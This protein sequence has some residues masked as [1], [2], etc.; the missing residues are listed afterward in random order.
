MDF[1]L[2]GQ[3]AMLQDAMRQ[4]SE[5]DIAPV[6]AA[7]SPDRPL[8]KEAMQAIYAVL[9]HNGLTAPRLPEAV[10][11]GGLSMLEYGLAFEQL[12]PTVA[13]S[14]VAHEGTAAR[15]Y[16][17]G[18]EAAMA[19][20]PSLIAGTLIGCTGSSEPGGGSDPRAVKTRA[21]ED[22]KDLLIT[23]RKMW[24]TNG[25]IADVMIVTCASGQDARGRGLVRRVVV[26]RA[27]SPYEAREIDVIG[28]RQGH[29]SEV[30]F[31]GCRVPASNALGEAGD[32]SRVLTLTWNGNRPLLG[33]SAVHL[34]Q[35]ALDL[36]LGYAGVR[37][38]F[39][40]PIGGKQL[41][42]E[43]LVDI[44]TSINAS[45]LLCYQ[46]LAQIDA[47]DRANA[48]SAMAKRFA[49]TACT[50]AID[51]AMQVHGAMGVARETGLEQLYRDVR[52]LPLP[53]GTN[54]VLTLIA[55]R[56][57]TGIDALR[58]GAGMSEAK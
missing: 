23:G 22:G 54:E 26:E 7:H 13:I 6:L 38:Q 17:S 58:S 27:T 12:P 10:G 30:L 56:E 41:V 21:V 19:L 43:R 39:G 49:T 3:Q 2:N 50:Q 46:A 8:P 20:L 11:G 42:Q 1:K 4:M 25:T 37:T 9:A 53:D 34:A 24:I 36:A 52:M 18:D 16:A 47:G 5:R 55:G 35:K 28:M 14:L 44:A 48:T 32:G 51:L 33:L 57:L 40:G 29:L 31:D 45:R 15:L